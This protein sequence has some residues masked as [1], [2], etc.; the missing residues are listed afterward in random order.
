M[1][2]FIQVKDDDI[3]ILPKPLKDGKKIYKFPFNKT[4]RV[5]LDLGTVEGLSPYKPESMKEKIMGAKTSSQKIY[6]N[7]QIVE[8]YPAVYITLAK[9]IDDLKKSMKKEDEEEI[10]EEFTELR[11]NKNKKLQDGGANL[12]NKLSKGFG[13]IYRKKGGVN[14]L[15]IQAMANKAMKALD[16]GIKIANVAMQEKENFKK[17]NQSGGA[18]ELKKIKKSAIDN[19]KKIYNMSKNTLNKGMQNINSMAANALK[20]M[21]G[22]QW[23][24][25][26]KEMKKIN[27]Q[28]RNMK[29]NYKKGKMCGGS[30]C[31]GC[32]PCKYAKKLLGGSSCSRK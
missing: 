14:P 16:S 7:G 15:M 11:D 21:K 5:D 20:L 6:V 17:D 30:H 3:K 25:A 10:M 24:E 4:L 19:T 12:L 13:F 18:F 29:S 23:K 26:N 8:E 22:G 9:S 27:K 28:C 31:G 2:A 1:F 32:K